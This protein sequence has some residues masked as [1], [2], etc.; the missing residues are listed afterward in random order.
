MKRLDYITRELLYLFAAHKKNSHMR[1]LAFFL[2]MVVVFTTTY[3]LILPAISLELDV[4]EEMPG[5]SLEDDINNQ[6]MSADTYDGYDE[7]L[8]TGE[9]DGYEEPVPLS[10][11]ALE[12]EDDLDG[13]EQAWIPED[14]SSV[15]YEQTDGLADE[16]ENDIVYEEET[17]LTVDDEAEGLSEEKPEVPTDEIPEEPYEELP[18]EPSEDSPVYEANDFV[19]DVPSE[20]Y[21]LHISYGEDAYIPAGAEFVVSPVD[22][23]SYGDRALEAVRSIR[24][25]DE[26]EKFS[27]VGLFDLTIYYEGKVVKPYGPVTIGIEFETEPADEKYQIVHFPG[28]GY[29]PDPEDTFEANLPAQFFAEELQESA[30]TSELSAEPESYDE[31]ASGNAAE[32]V[33]E[34]AAPDISADFTTDMTADIVSAAPADALTAVPDDLYALNAEPEVFD[35]V[36]YGNEAVFTTGSF[37]YFAIVG[38][39]IEKT[40]LAS[41][42]LNYRITA[43]YG[44]ETSIPEEAE[45]SVEEILPEE[46]D[47]ESTASA[48]DE[49]VAMTENALGMEEGSAGYIRL[50]DIKIVDKDDHEIKYQPAEGTSVDVRIELAD[51][52]SEELNVV[53]FADGVEEGEKVES[54]TESVDGR[55]AVSF[56]ASGFSVYGIVDLDSA[57][58]AGSVDELD[59]NSYYLSMDDGSNRYYY[60]DP[61][62]LVS[63]AWKFQRA[64]TLDAATRFYFEKSEQ[65]EQGNRFYIYTY[66][67]EGNKKYVN[68]KIEN[69]NLR[70]YELGDD[71]ESATKYTVE[72]HTNGSPTSFV[73]YHK[74]ANKE[75]YYWN[76]NGSYFELAKGTSAS[77]PKNNSTKI[78]L[79]KIGDNE[80]A[81]SDPYGL[82][83]QSLGIIWNVND[84]SGS[85][86]LSSAG[87]MNS[88][89]TLSDGSGKVNESVNILKN[90]STT[91]RIDPVSRTDRVFV[92][93]N[94]DITMWTFACCGPAQ[95]Y[96]TAVV[97][98]ELKYVR[99]DDTVNVGT[100]NKGISL[101]DTP[102]E[103]CKITVTEGTGTYSGKYK[104]SSNGRT[105]Y[106][107]NGNYY[108]VADSQNVSN[109]W[110]YFAEQ[111]NLNDDDFVVYTA[112]KVSVSGP[113]N[114]DGTIDYDVKDGDQV[115]L[116]TRIW[117]ETTLEYEYYAIDYDGMLVRA[118]MSGDNISWV[119]SKVNTMLWD[120][121]EYHELDAD[122]NETDVPNY[123]YELQNNYSGKYIAPQ[124]TGDEFLADS[125]IGINLNGRRYNEYYSTILAWDTP[126]YD[127]AMLMVPENEYQLGSAPIAL[128]NDTTITRDF[129]FAIMTNEEE[130]GELST[131][132]TIDHTSFG[133]SVKMINYPGGSQSTANG[134]YHNMIQTN[135]LGQTSK[136]GSTVYADLL[137]KNLSENGYPDVTLSGYTD[138][139]LRELYADCSAASETPVNHTFLAS[140]YSE[141]GYFEYD[142]TQN[143]AHLITSADDVWYGMPMPGGGT[144]GIGDFVIYDQLG[145]TSETGDTRRHGQ[146][147]PYNDLAK[148]VEADEDGNLVITP[149]YS[150]STTMYNTTNIK[151]QAITSLDPRYGEQLYQ[152]PN[153][154]SNKLAPNVDHYF[155]MEM[156]ASFMQSESGLDAWGH[157]LI[158]EFSGDDDFWL[159][160]DGKLVLDLGGIHSACDGSVNF[161]T[162]EVIV[163]GKKTNLRTLYREAYL[164]E[165]PDATEGEITAYLDGF[166]KDGGTVFKDYSG[167]TMK[168]FYMERGAGA[169]NLHMRF[170]LAPYV[171]G[172]VQLKKEVSGTDTVST[173]FPFQI[174]YE[175]K[176][177]GLFVQVGSTGHDLSVLDANTGDPISHEDTYTID[178]AVYDHVYFLT[179]GQTASIQLPSE[180][181][182]YYFVECGINPNTYDQ[183]TANGETI[184]GTAA[185]GSDAESSSLKDYKIEED[186]VSG[187][188]KVIYNNHVS[189]SAQKTL[190]VTKRL[191]RDYEKTT[192]IYSGNDADADNTNFR[193]RVYIGSGTDKTVDGTGYAVYN[194]GKYYVK[195]SAGEYCIWQN[196]GFVSTGKTDFSELDTQRTEGAWKSEAEQATFYTSPGG[197]V[198]NI[199]AGYSIEIPG[200]MAG[201]P[202]YIEERLDEIPAGYNL[203]DYTTT[204]GAYSSD[205]TGAEGSSGT[206]AA[207]D[208]NRTVSV[209]NQHGYG[210]TVDKVWSDAA[211]MES[212]DDIYFG[213]YLNGTLIEGS[214]RRLHHPATSINWFF[215]ELEENKTLNDYQVYELELTKNGQSITA[216]DI[217]VDPD[218]GKVTWDPSSNISVTKKE[219]NDSINIGGVSNEYGYSVSYS[220]TVGYERQELSAQEIADKVN[221]RTDTVS[222]SRPGIKFVKTDLSGAPLGGAKFV[223]TDDSGTIRKTFSS[224]EDGLIVVSYLENDKTY[225]L[226]ETAAPYGYQTLISS[227]T[228][229]KTVNTAGKTVVY[230]NGEVV[231]GSVKDE[232]NTY[233]LYTVTQV[234]E[235]TADNMP[236]ITIRNKDYTLKAVKVDAYSYEPMKDVKF[237]LYKEVYETVNGVPDPDYP[238]P[239]YT[240]MSGYES[241]ITDENGVIPGIF[242][243]NSETPGGLTAGTYYLREETPSGYNSL[244]F[245]IRITIS[246]TGEVTLQSAKRPTQSGHW[247]FGSVAESIANVAYNNGIMQITVMNTPKDPVRIKKLEMGTENKVL[248]GVQFKLYKIGQINDDGLPREDESAVITGATDEDGILLLGGLE[249]NTSYYLYETEALPGYNMLTAP[250][251]IT[252]VGPNTINAS[253]H[254]APLD[255]QKVKDSNNND[256]WEITI[257]NSTG[258]ELPSTGGPGTNLIYLIGFMLTGI[259]GAGLVMRKRRRDAA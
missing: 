41:D 116:Y 115:V 141:T 134:N 201:T 122:G 151:G 211:F 150:Y 233:E 190:T 99:F 61:L 34:A 86:M 104:F 147:F 192:E 124:V 220:Y 140:T 49:Y 5:I 18:E 42:G 195:N 222:N 11:P 252:T 113:V 111:S 258:Y 51:A 241:L 159:Y 106:N 9:Y 204:E 66:D 93:Q 59:G 236:T 13:F 226:T 174:W 209:H 143:F 39:T 68:L 64:T 103:R 227:I 163:N 137:K 89:I 256:V 198:D 242:M 208:S 202:Y 223:L 29:Q 63:N 127:Y 10:E 244:G 75:F 53:H 23:M 110:M 191:W 199:K 173:Q 224:A 169:S 225:T 254:G 155:G 179:P 97:N 52:E 105:L 43:T 203:I 212:H 87:T 139:N 249:E 32:A 98:G 38:T 120:F 135:V 44:I 184:E 205:N 72:I 131:V 62:V 162:G 235:P 165:N 180:D 251:I 161:R 57:E 40:V 215:R 129:Y 232:T 55:Q 187:R 125:P 28:T 1:R 168:M 138:H 181:T 76:R 170:N 171:N 46:N 250:V 153:N 123:Y 218:T 228:I 94:S 91:V 142:C 24:E 216:D 246:D 16:T 20:N 148:K 167:H 101:V 88:Q 247:T 193:F 207:N 175:D 154:T 81:P 21:L 206:I 189:D 77:V 188:K 79:T 19:L 128:A 132:Q 146:Y 3:A 108:T 54:R 213:V 84:V 14:E 145:T 156:D 221:S 186:T 102:D 78:I 196:G 26:G 90:K 126:Y 172:E 245:D 219:A 183:V 136:N 69:N 130:S 176:I 200:L 230:V 30:E 117:N 60:T 50:F 56:E 152:I 229:K 48:Y 178:G 83:G 100:G 160:V 96:I 109:V 194:T 240:P 25:P 119:G 82:D 4:A 74:K 231:N 58:T 166:F 114:E 36:M 107:N 80:T 217:N 35:T 37:S 73:I 70:Y 248:E 164:E 47:D 112:K 144:Y 239:D 238:M 214:V 118:Y 67:E 133:I 15:I 185:T 177:S 210:L 22:D 71:E 149:A 197:A 255:C 31:A 95:Y 2:A 65:D 6:D 182:K 237:A 253:L 12:Y 257:Y 234:D 259:A 157:D 243:K 27:V 121:T 7:L 17:G 92:A 33:L 8:L 85:G 45:L 158:F